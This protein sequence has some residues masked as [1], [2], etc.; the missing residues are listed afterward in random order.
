M[1]ADLLRTPT[2]REQLL[3]QLAQ[4]VVALDAS[5]VPTRPAGS[6]TP[7]SLERAVTTALD[8]VA[9]Q[10][11]ADRRRRAPQ[12]CC[13]LPDT[14]AGALQVG[15]LDPLV[16]RQE[17]TADLPH[18]EPLQRR[19]EPDRRA[20]MVGLVTASPVVPRGPRNADLPRRGE[21][22]PP[23]LTQL[24]EPLTLGRLRTPP[25]PLLHTTRR[26]QHDSR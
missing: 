14:H 11:P 16:L 10:L 19:D 23:P 8:R 15:D 17:P 4:L 22:A 1:T 12:P 6:G 5:P 25:R 7:V 9:A 2:L 3:E 13:D 21:N 18:R 20:V 26:R 24:H